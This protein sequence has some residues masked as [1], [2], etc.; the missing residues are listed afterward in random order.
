MREQVVLIGAGSA[1]FT[2]GLVADLVRSGAEV[3][4]ALVDV[5][6]VALDIVTKLASRMIAARRAPITLSASVD[7]R[8]AFI[9]CLYTGTT[10]KR[11]A[12]RGPFV[13]RSL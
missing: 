13:Q 8:E 1:M 9:C 12:S 5:D 3:D 4:L 10:K 2:R 11:A 6:P 7:R